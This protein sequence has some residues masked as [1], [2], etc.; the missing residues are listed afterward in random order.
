M[1]DQR[2]AETVFFKVSIGN[3]LFHYSIEVN[4]LGRPATVSMRYFIIHE[5]F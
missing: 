4:S 5:W 2:V 3:S 1:V